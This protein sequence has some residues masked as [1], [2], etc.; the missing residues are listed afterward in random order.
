MPITAK[1]LILHELIGLDV[2]IL[3]STNK[4]C[5]GISGKVVDETKNVISIKTSKGDKKIQKDGTMF[6]F[7]LPDQKNVKV[8][9]SLLVARPEERIKIKLRKW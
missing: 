8:D 7:T 2:Q 9:G 3:G 6:M 1:N 4:S 5:V